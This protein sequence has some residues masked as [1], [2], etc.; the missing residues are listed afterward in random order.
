MVY[1]FFIVI[2]FFVSGCNSFS[3]QKTKAR[4]FYDVDIYSLSGINEV[5]PGDYPNV[6]IVDSG[7]YRMLI[8]HID[9]NNYIE[10][11]YIRDSNKWVLHFYERDDTTDIYTTRIITSNEVVE[12]SYSD[13]NN[14]QIYDF[15]ILR[16]DSMI[17][18]L[19]VLDLKR[20]LI[21]DDLTLIK[22]NA[23]YKVKFWFEA[24]G[25]SVQFYKLFYDPQNFHN[26]PIKVC[27]SSDRRSFFWWYETQDFFTQIPCNK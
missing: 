4:F 18:Y 9:S 15:G 24:N 11:N 3:P 23:Q 5:D 8:Y 2:V 22:N 12:F 19:P 1:Q 6:E 17:Y 25:E 26:D 27:Y 10:R 7:T 14:Y 13:T 20:K 16:A 21:L